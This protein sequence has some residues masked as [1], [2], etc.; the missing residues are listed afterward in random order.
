[1]DLKLRRYSAKDA[2]AWEE[3]CETAYQSTFLHSRRFLSY[4]E[5]RFMDC[6]LILEISGKWVGV[7]LAAQMPGDN[8]CVVS[9]P[10]ITYGGILHNR[11]LTGE[12]MIAAISMIC[13][14]Y[15]DCG[16][17]RLI[18]K[19]VP[20]FYH[21]IPAQDDLYA[22]FRIGAQR[23][24]CDLSSTIDLQNRRPAGSRRKRSL[25]KAQR[26]GVVIMVGTEHLPE[27]WDVLTD[28]LKKKHKTSPVHT[29]AEVTM[30]AER[31]PNNISCVVGLV[32]GQVVAGVLLFVT[33]L[34]THAQYI[35]SNSQGYDVSALDVVF[36][37]CIAQAESEGKRWF[38]FGIST[39]NNGQFL[40]EGL[41]SFKSEFGG[42]GTIHEFFEI[43]LRK[44][45]DVT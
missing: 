40:N 32:G 15:L 44:A 9:H 6:S 19:A 27:L 12:R 42:G 45:T 3:F 13:Q 1:M 11:G 2:K 17:N 24:R 7:F 26:A 22:L 34:V 20:S 10:G 35:A 23:I 41:Y 39:E 4:H 28:N 43:D 8:L 38:D 21:T 29:L 37:F 5:D 30:L 14:Y 18:Y 16:Y 36:E 31:F 33:S 25:K